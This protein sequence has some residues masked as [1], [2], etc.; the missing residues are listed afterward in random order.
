MNNIQ[1]SNYNE[2]KSRFTKPSGKLLRVAFDPDY[3]IIETNKETICNEYEDSMFYEPKPEYM[4]TKIIS[5]LFGE[6]NI[7]IGCRG[8]IWIGGPGTYTKDEVSELESKHAIIDTMETPDKCLS[9][10]FDMDGYM[11]YYIFVPND[12]DIKS[13]AHKIIMGH[14]VIVFNDYV[15]LES[16]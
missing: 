4:S 1:N 14:E 3:V 13:M 2:I 16:F 11:S 9:C 7:V 15:E 12:T 5:E 6:T 8:G 10:R